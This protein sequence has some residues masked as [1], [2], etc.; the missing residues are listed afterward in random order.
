MYGSMEE[1]PP[2]AAPALGPEEVKFVRKLMATNGDDARSAG[3][4]H[5]S[6]ASSASTLPTLATQALSTSTLAKLEA[7][8]DEVELQ[9]S[10]W[11]SSLFLFNPVAGRSASLFAFML[12]VVNVFLQGSFAFYLIDGLDDK[13]ITND[14]V[15]ELKWWRRHVAHYGDNAE[16]ERILQCI[17]KFSAAEWKGCLYDEKFECGCGNDHGINYCCG[18]A[19]QA[20]AIEI[21]SECLARE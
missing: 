11:D 4:S 13:P 21:W 20:E 16:A 17:K 12:L 5:E 6:Q 2:A 3:L 18:S 9:P 10:V 15:N 7:A 1:S 8:S 19:D 14:D